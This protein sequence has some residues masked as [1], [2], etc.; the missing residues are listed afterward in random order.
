MKYRPCNH[1]SLSP[2]NNVL[3]LTAS[4]PF[5]VSHHIDVMW[6]PTHYRSE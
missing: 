2:P 3:Q 4:S 6:P 1:P 5:K